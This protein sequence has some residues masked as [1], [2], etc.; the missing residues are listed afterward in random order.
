MSRGAQHIDEELLI[1]FIVGE[2]DGPE[3]DLVREWIDLSRE[4]KLRFEQLQKVWLA[5]KNPTD[6]IPANVHVDAAWRHLKSRMDAAPE[7]EN[8]PGSGGRSLSFYMVRVAAALVMGIFIYVIYKYQARQPDFVQLASGE[9]T[10]SDT[11]LPDGSVISLNQNTV[12]EYPDQFAERERRIKITGEAFFDV[13]P[14]TARPFIVEAHRATITV[15]GTSFNVKALKED[16]AVEVLVVEGLVELANPERSRTTKLHVGE[17]G[18]FIKESD[19]VKKETEIDVES[20]YWLNK[21]LLFRDTKLSVVFETLE[22][23]Y[24]VHIDV[25]NEQILNCRLTAKF[26]NETIDNIINHISTIF[27]LEITK[28][29]NNILMKGNGCQ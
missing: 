18:I 2:T 27:E 22:N 5:T 21:T 9:S 11:P 1:R 20:L 6:A 29:A 4:H 17:K 12:I 19:E 14:D 23:L 7:R 13:K 25:E 8:K 15:L 26:S 3:S 10:I 16:E 28:D 24:K